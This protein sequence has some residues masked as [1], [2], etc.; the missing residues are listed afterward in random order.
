M[1]PDVFITI[2]LGGPVVLAGLA[3]ALVLFRRFRQTSSY[4][5]AAQTADVGRDRP[6]NRSEH[7]AVH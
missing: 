2:A 7:D 5:E 1:N 3:V 6:V 4:G